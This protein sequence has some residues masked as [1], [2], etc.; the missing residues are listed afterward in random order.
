VAMGLTFMTGVVAGIPGVEFVVSWC[1]AK[2][3]DFHILVVE[4]FGEMKWFMVEIEPY[5][6]QIF[7]FYLVVFLPLVGGYLWKR[8]KVV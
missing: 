8:R 5:H 7:L 2:L 3:L 4:F 1:A 6:S